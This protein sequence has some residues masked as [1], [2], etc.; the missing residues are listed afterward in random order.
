MEMLSNRIDVLD[1][2]LKAKG[3]A[4]R[5]QIISKIKNDVKH[6]PEREPTFLKLINNMVGF[7]GKQNNTLVA[8]S[9]GLNLSKILLDAV[10]STIET[11]TPTTIAE[12]SSGLKP[13]KEDFKER[14]MELIEGI[15]NP[16]LNKIYGGKRT[17]ATYVNRKGEKVSLGADVPKD[18]VLWIRKKNKEGVPAGSIVSQLKT[19]IESWITNPKNKE[20]LAK[21][22]QELVGK[23]FL[24]QE[25]ALRKPGGIATELVEIVLKGRTTKEGAVV[26][27]RSS[28]PVKPFNKEK[29]FEVRVK[30]Q[31]EKNPKLSEKQIRSSLGRIFK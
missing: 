19:H 6:N 11:G 1:K 13:M 28:A 26:K 9:V 20:V 31:M 3:I 8:E 18:V 25:E 24:T 2:A 7:L 15:V 23:D 10:N 21:K 4:T 5:V 22:Y 30:R 29:D 14:V 17:G 27:A 12:M 16:D